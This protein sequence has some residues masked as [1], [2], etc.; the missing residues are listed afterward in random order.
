MILSRC[1]C[2]SFMNQSERKEDAVDIYYGQG[3]KNGYATDIQ[4]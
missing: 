4:R 3:L 2:D 1:Q